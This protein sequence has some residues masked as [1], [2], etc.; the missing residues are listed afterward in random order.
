MQ[1]L[2]KVIEKYSGKSVKCDWNNKKMLGK[3][4]VFNGCILHS[5]IYEHLNEC[6]NTPSWTP[7]LEIYS[8]IVFWGHVE[9]EALLQ[10]Y[11]A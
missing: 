10:A 4:S 5:Y 9:G 6:L 2:V 7:T 3:T 8:D 11:T 1:N